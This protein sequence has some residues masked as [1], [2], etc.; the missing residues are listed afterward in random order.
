MRR[1]GAEALENL[2]PKAIAKTKMARR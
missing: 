1:V 2:I